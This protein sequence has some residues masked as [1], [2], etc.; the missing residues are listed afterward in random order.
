[1][2]TI[3]R[4]ARNSAGQVVLYGDRITDSMAKAMSETKRRRDIQTAYNIEHNITPTT[5]VKDTTNSILETLRGR[6]E[7][8]EVG[9][10]KQ[11]W[12]ATVK[13][14]LESHGLDIHQVIKKLEKE[15]KNAA[16]NLEFE[17]AAELRDQLRVLQ[18]DLQNK[19]VEGASK[20]K[21]KSRK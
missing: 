21:Q 15:M 3:G 13:D 2:Q 17:R 10:T 12:V 6:R 4:A 7:E 14:V 5:I 8:L 11:K 9:D 16:R 20:E 1:V 19:R 18:E